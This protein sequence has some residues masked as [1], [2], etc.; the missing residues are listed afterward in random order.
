MIVFIDTDILID[1]ALKR[2][3]FWEN[4]AKI[5]DLCQE[6]KLK[7]FIA[8]HTLSNFYYIISSAENK[9]ETKQFLSDLLKFIDVAKTGSEEAKKALVMDVPDF[10]DALQISAS[11]S[12]NAEYII[13]RNKKHYKRSPI[14]ALTPDEFLKKNM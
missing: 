4:S 5:I 7:G 13:T 10:E 1:V 14:T 2:E 12:C 8:W 6:K 11:I 3:N 9:K